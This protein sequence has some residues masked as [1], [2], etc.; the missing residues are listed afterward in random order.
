MKAIISVIAAALILTSCEKSS[1]SGIGNTLTETRPVAPFTGVQADGSSGVEIV[2][3]TQQKVEV[4]GYANLLPVYETYVSNGNLV[5]KFRSDYS[6]ISHNNIKVRIEVPQLDFIA[7]NGSGNVYI[8]NFVG[9]DLTT[10]VNG[11]G[12]INA[13]NCKYNSIKTRVNGSGKTKAA[14]IAVKDADASISGSG[15]IE[16]N[17]SNS[18]KARISGSG[19]IKYFGNPSTTDIEVS[20]SGKVRRL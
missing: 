9:T 10:F 6:N 8:Q 15:V 12:E 4:I 17:T 18:F 20:G 19:E 14:Q 13:S 3:G 16:V 1:I 5:V 7:V 2:K 11:S